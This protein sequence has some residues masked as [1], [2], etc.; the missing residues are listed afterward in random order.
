[1]LAAYC[2]QHR[3]C[4]SNLSINAAYTDASVLFAGSLVL[5]GANFGA[6]FQEVVKQQVSNSNKLRRCLHMLQLRSSWQCKHHCRTCDVNQH[7]V[8]QCLQCIKN[9]SDARP[10]TKAARDGCKWLP[11]MCGEQGDRG[12]LCA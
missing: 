9:A 3:K 7:T 12:C 10:D 2:L 11:E 8:Y 6:L 5:T 4:M 1:M